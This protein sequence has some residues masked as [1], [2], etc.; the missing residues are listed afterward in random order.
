M[1]RNVKIAGLLC[2]LSATC[3]GVSAFAFKGSSFLKL[4]A[5]DSTRWSHY[6]YSAPKVEQNGCKEYW[7][8]CGSHEHQFTKPD[9][10]DSLIDEKGAPSAEFLSSLTESDDRYLEAYHTLYDFED[11]KVP[12]ACVA[13]QFVTA[14]S[15][16]SSS[17]VEG[18]KALK[19][20]T[21]NNDFK[22]GL[23]K[24]WLDEIF[25]DA[26]VASIAFDAK[27]TAASQNFRYCTPSGPNGNAQ[28]FEDYEA[29]SGIGTNWKTF[30]FTR[31]MYNA[32][33]DSSFMIK[34]NIGGGDIYIDNIRTSA[35]DIYTNRKAL[36]FETNTIVEKTAT[37][38][39]NNGIFSVL[40]ANS[41]QSAYVSGAGVTPASAGYS[42]D[43]KS[44]GN[45]SFY[46]VKKSGYVSVSINIDIVNSI[47]GDYVLVD[48][49]S[50]T[51]INSYSS[52]KGI[53]DGM[54]NAFERQTPGNKWF[55]LVL[56]KTTGITTD[57]RILTMGGSAAGTIY[58]DNIRGISALDDLETA[59]SFHAGQYGYALDYKTDTTEAAGGTI[60]DTN[61]NYTF[62]VN[63]ANLT[64]AEITKE[65]VS[66]GHYS[67]K[68]TYSAKGYCALF[69][70]PNLLNV[71]L[72]MGFSVAFDIWASTSFTGGSEMGSQVNGH[73]GQWTT[74]TLSPDKFEGHT[75]G[76]YNGRFSTANFNDAGV[77]YVD[78]FRLVAP[79]AE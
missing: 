75:T 9:V 7:V 58:L 68:F 38:N 21:A 36:N 74:V 52:N 33:D 37:E 3:I 55:T 77:F 76:T 60:R 24:E 42:Y 14:A 62:M 28:P 50:T 35:I 45:R 46:F 16:D 34:G 71:Y 13:N 17:G 8:S 59:Y 26:N 57:G 78:N 22:F 29:G 30:Y 5:E 10:S 70:N 41:V 63:G 66:S 48:M 79:V 51:A 53:T 25:S 47:P 56:N 43:I 64:S 40:I 49:Y 2:V 65:K 23:N 19:L 72:P 61:K 54:N 4:K 6:S 32:W 11:G 15:V 20:T 12:A 27:A 39:P 31:A 18:S 1:K 73:I 44:E 69:I 67:A